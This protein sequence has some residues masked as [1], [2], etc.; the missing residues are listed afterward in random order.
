MER[1]REGMQCL[2]LA[3]CLGTTRLA[4]L[5]AAGLTAGLP[6]HTTPPHP[7]RQFV[8]SKALP[9]GAQGVEALAAAVDLGKGLQLTHMDLDSLR[10][11][12]R[13]PQLAEA[14]AA[15]AAAQRSRRAGGGRS[16][17]QP[18]LRGLQLRAGVLLRYA[19]RGG[20]RGGQQGR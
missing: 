19:C 18:Q 7:P 4:S 2:Q 9:G 20:Q 16:L 14:L 15:R 6:H 13:L 12:K 1:L 11:P 17:A 10:D 8:P 5:N 3:Y